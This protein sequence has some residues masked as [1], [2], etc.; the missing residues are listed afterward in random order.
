MTNITLDKNNTMIHMETT[1]DAY[2]IESFRTNLR[3]M[4]NCLVKD[5]TPFGT[6]YINRALDEYERLFRNSIGHVDMVSRDG[7]EVKLAKTNTAFE[8]ACNLNWYRANGYAIDSF[9]ALG[10]GL[11]MTFR[12]SD[13]NNLS[14]TICRRFCGLLAA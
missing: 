13:V 7:N 2:A 9:A 4:L 11:V 8:F 1:D 6:K 12:K 14:N 10:R 3:T 5:G